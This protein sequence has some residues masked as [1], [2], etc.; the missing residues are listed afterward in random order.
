MR[1]L[2]LMGLTYHTH[3]LHLISKALFFQVHLTSG[4]TQSKAQFH[5][6]GYS[7]CQSNAALRKLKIEET[8]CL[9][10]VAAV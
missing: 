4:A 7:L 10:D 1:M 9:L 5:R 8:T 2:S 3:T 6:S